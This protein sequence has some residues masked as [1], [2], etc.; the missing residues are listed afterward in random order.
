M[1]RYRQPASESTAADPADPR[2]PQTLITE[3]SGPSSYERA[4]RVAHAIW[5]E[6]RL[7]IVIV[8]CY[9]AAGGGWL[10]SRGA[11]WHLTWSYA[12]VWQMWFVATVLWIFLEYLRSPQRVRRILTIERI[13]GA[14]LVVAVVAPFQSTFQSLKA[15]IPDF[16]WDSWLSRVDI[17]IHGRP[18]WTLWHPTDTALGVVAGFYSAWLLMVFAFVIWVSWTRFRILR[19]QALVSAALLWIVGGTIAAWLL[20]SAGPCYYG[21]VVQGPDPYAQMA[22]RISRMPLLVNGL[23]RQLWRLRENKAHAPFAG[24]SAM[25]SMH[26]GMAVLV[27]VAAWRRSKVAGVVCW[28]YAAVIQV[29]SVVLAW[30]YAIDGYVAAV[31]V[32]V[33]W[34]AAGRLIALDKRLFA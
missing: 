26:V 14:L 27:A 30:H 32:A 1:T 18:P 12:L 6:H 11:P 34:F 15:A 9:L 13:A 20:A 3:Q 10:I 19:A 8:T 7:L 31:I 25:P 24:I 33:C 21:R 22:G 4:I 29:G 5:V 2:R 17:A 23:Q 16:S 28:A